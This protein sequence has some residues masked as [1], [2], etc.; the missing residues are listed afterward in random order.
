MGGRSRFLSIVV[1]EFALQAK[2]SVFSSSTFILSVI[3][4]TFF[5]AFFPYQHTLWDVLLLLCIH[6]YSGSEGETEEGE[7][8]TSN[9]AQAAGAEG[10]NRTTKGDRQFDISLPAQHLVCVCVCAL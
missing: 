9:G 1:L 10:E 2:F 4:I 3:S 6:W 8:A 5:T 7:L